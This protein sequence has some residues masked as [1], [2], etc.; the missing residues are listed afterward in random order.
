[1]AF[2]LVHQF[3]KECGVPT[4]YVNVVILAIRGN[5]MALGNL[6]YYLI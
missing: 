2:K 1:M 4:K 3:E 6:I 5:I